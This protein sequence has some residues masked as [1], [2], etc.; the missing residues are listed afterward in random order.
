MEKIIPKKEW[1]AAIRLNHWLRVIFISILIVTGLYIA[2]PFTV[3][4]GWTGEKMIMA[5]VRFWHLL[6]GMGLGLLFIWRFYLSFFSR[7][8]ADWKDFLAW[9]NWT[10]VKQE[11]RFY[12]LL[13]KE[14]P[15][16]TYLYDPLQSLSYAVFLAML[17]SLILTGTIMMGAGYDKGLTALVYKAVKPVEI[18]LGGLATVRWIHHILMWGVILFMTVHVNMAFLHDYLF[19]EGIVSSMISGTIFHRSGT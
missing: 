13:S 7:F 15:K 17:F 4:K 12:L 19:K 18:W 9:M 8:H 1:S 11:A 10:N 14:P 5:E 2:E 16:H 3:E 6:F